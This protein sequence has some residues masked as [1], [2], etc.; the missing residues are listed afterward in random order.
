MSSEK[1]HLVYP[2]QPTM[3]NKQNTPQNAKTYR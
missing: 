2:T 3:Y 1:K